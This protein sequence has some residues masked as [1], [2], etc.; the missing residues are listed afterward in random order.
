MCQTFFFFSIE[1][2]NRSMIKCMWNNIWPNWEVGFFFLNVDCNIC[3]LLPLFRA[4]KGLKGRKTAGSWKTIFAIGKPMRIGSL[5]QPNM[6]H[7]GMWPSSSLCSTEMGHYHH[8]SVWTVGC[9]WHF[10]L[11]YLSICFCLYS[12]GC[13]VDSVTLRSAKSED[14]LSSQHSGSGRCS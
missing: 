10:P 7:F 9:F 11:V 8:L 14:S 3:V 5:F 13:R 12:Q 1:V 6:A 2:T 4:K